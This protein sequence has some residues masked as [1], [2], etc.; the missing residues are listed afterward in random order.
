MICP[1]CGSNNVGHWIG[2]QGV[3]YECH[4]CGHGW[5]E[6]FENDDRNREMDRGNSSMADHPAADLA[7]EYRSPT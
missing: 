7:N 3:I 5:L 1:K 4:N 2:G 6:E